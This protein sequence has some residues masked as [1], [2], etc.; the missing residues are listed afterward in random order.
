MSDPVYGIDVSYA[1][2]NINWDDAH[3]SGRFSFV[4]NRATYGANPADDD[5]PIFVRNHDECR[6]LNIPVG[7]YHFYRFSSGASAQANHFLQ[8]SYGRLGTLLPMVDIEEQSFDAIPSMT[9][10]ISSIS[11]V[12]HT[13]E[14]K[15]GKRPI[16]Y[17]NYDTWYKYLQNTDAFAGHQLWLAQ[18]LSP[19]TGLYGGWKD[20]LI[21]QDRTIR[22]PGISNLV[23]FDIL[24]PRH[25]LSDLSL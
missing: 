13:I 2:G 3:A 14:A 19:D 9:A 20:W 8:A 1:N 21:W 24:N 11:T 23:D 4:Y 10:A 6:R 25:V 16:I 5:G 17:T 22:V 15:V 7:A 18:T 12:L